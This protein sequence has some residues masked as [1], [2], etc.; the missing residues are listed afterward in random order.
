MK[1]KVKEIT[2]ESLKDFPKDIENMSNEEMFAVLRDFMKNSVE[3][4]GEIPDVS[5][6][7]KDFDT[8]ELSY[9]PTEVVE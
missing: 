2:K 9:D 4:G 1:I 8:D 7:A 5:K 3:V 6:L